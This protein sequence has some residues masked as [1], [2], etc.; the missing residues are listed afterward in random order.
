MGLGDPPTAVENDAE[1]NNP[2][3]R[4]ILDDQRRI[5]DRLVVLERIIPT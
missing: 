1:Y 4:S 3:S 5:A 2:T